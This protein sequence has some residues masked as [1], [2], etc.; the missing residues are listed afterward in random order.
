MESETNDKEF[1]DRFLLVLGGLTAGAVAVYFIAGQIASGTQHVWQAQEPQAST[2]AGERIGPVGK[3]AI[4]GQT[5]PKPAVVPEPVARVA[6]TGEQIYNSGCN[7]CH[8]AGIAGAPQLGDADNWS[9]RI[10]QGLDVLRGH[11]VNG[12]QGSAGVMPAKGGLV[13]LSDDDVYLAIEYMLE[14]VP[15]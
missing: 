2:R 5:Q 15:Q 6:Q 13:T 12:Y 8:N 7:V 10:A 1:F 14:S 3:V 11:A 4:A 9:P